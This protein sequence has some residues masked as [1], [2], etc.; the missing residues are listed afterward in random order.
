VHEGETPH[1]ILRDCDTSIER[2]M[3]EVQSNW[4]SFVDR[5]GSSSEVCVIEASFFNNLIETLFIHNVEKPQIIHFA[6]EL[7]KL[8]GPLNPTLVYLVQDD[9]EKALERNF[10]RRGVGFKNYVIEFATSTPLARGRGW[11]G[12]PGMVLFWQEFVALTDEL[13][14]K[15]PHRKLMIENTA[16]DWET[17]NQ[18]VLDYLGIPRIPEQNISPIVARNLI[19][20]YKDPQS[21][22]DFLV[23]F[24]DDDL[25]INLFLDVKSRLVQ[26]T[27]KEF[28]AE[29]WPFEIRF[30]SGDL[31][32]MSVLRIGGRN[33]D[34]LALVGT[35]AEKASA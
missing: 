34:Y 17:Y 18:Q 27:E 8:V 2:Y 30:E 33:V 31:G 35:I 25:T 14:N 6:A 11:E 20:R 21:D 1:P 3:T 4:V 13:F 5:V 19:G 22:R 10:S 24:E 7:Q 23:Q 15:F 26:R 32:G 28:F 16:G 12:Y 9:V 29:G